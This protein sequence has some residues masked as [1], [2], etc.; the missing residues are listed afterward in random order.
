MFCIT[1]INNYIYNSIKKKK[2]NYLRASNFHTLS[3]KWQI[4]LSK[5]QPH[6]NAYCQ[7]LNIYI[8]IY[9]S[10]LEIAT[11]LVAYAPEM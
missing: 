7:A 2:K 5:G 1:T 8:Y 9:I 4:Y 10:G 6:E 3:S 11:I